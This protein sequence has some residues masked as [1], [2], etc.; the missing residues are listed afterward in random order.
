MGDGGQREERI[1]LASLG[2]DDDAGGAGPSGGGGWR[3][4]PM[5][6]RIWPWRN[7]CTA[8]SLMQ[9]LSN[10]VMMESRSGVNLANW[11]ADIAM[12]LSQ[13]MG[14]KLM[15]ETT[16]LLETMQRNKPLGLPF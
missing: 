2:G 11:G 7:R 8:L 16:A 13:S 12:A 5:S 14:R 1:V 15:I 4:S 10:L 6:C 9:G 3:K